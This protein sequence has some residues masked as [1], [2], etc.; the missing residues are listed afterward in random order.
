MQLNVVEILCHF[1][2][3]I[4]KARRFLTVFKLSNLVYKSSAYDHAS[5]TIIKIIQDYCVCCQ[6]TMLSVVNTKRTPNTFV[7][8]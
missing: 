8:S 4:I 7:L 3:P 5:Y 2:K 1:Y 6:L